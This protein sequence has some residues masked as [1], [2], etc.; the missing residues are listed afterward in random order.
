MWWTGVEVFLKKE[1]L[2]YKHPEKGIDARVDSL[3]GWY[4]ERVQDNM[5]T[6]ST[7]DK[8]MSED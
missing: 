1:K 8:D 5:F 3:L 4:W 6:Q 7:R 2:W